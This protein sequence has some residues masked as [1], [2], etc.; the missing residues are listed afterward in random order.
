[1]ANKKI[2]ID[3]QRTRKVYG[4]VQR[5]PEK[6][7]AEAS[8][9]DCEAA[10]LKLDWKESVR[11]ASIGDISLPP[12]SPNGPIDGVTL[13]DGERFLLKNQT[14][15]SENGI[16]VVNGSSWDR[17]D[18]AIP[19]TTLTCGATVY[20]ES[21]TSNEKT[22]WTLETV[23]VTLGGNQSWVYFEVW[24][25]NGSEIKTD[26]PVSI[27]ADYPS[28][29]GT[30][31]FFYV[32][33]SRQS[34][35]P[36]PADTHISVFGGDVLFSGTIDVVKGDGFYGDF[37]EISGSM[38]L[39]TGSIGTQDATSG[40][41]TFFVDSSTG[42]AG[43]SGSLEVADPIYAYGGMS[44][45]LTKLTDGT[46]YLVAGSNITIT[47]QSN[48]SV[49]ITSLGGGGGGAAGSNY[50]IQYCDAF[51]V[52]DAS[53]SLIFNYNNNTFAVTGSIE[54]KGPVL[55]SEDNVYDLGSSL[56][57]WAN[58]YTGDLHLKNDRGDWTLIEEEEYLSVKNNKTNKVY[59]IVIEPVS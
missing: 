21:G 44:G 31:V 29:I 49:V 13:S 54:S 5:L 30:D 52:L 43:F 18:D 50:Q 28:T 3:R 58:I 59:K 8:C 45:S 15:S 57:R 10:M 1:M 51:G 42:N 20:V 53:P 7:A 37:L 19:G 27:G 23:N 46:S 9:A 39:T 6:V 2:I 33:G 26:L 11:C 25:T 38:V 35:G 17:A 22:K 56:L 32:S 16:Y 36:L 34:G 41:Y 4:F 48:G 55:P 24:L 40:D 12:A 47:S 14:T